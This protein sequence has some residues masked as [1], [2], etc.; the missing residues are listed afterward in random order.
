MEKHGQKRETSVKRQ[1]HTNFFL[2]FFSNAHINANKKAEEAKF[3]HEKHRNI[4]IL[5]N[6]SFLAHY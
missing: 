5:S 1:S 3:Q 2:F 4:Y 6:L